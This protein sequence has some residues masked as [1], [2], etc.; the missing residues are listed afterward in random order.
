MKALLGV[1]QALLRMP[2]PLSGHYAT[3]RTADHRTAAGVAMQEF[4]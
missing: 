3:H 2:V 1:H 4:T